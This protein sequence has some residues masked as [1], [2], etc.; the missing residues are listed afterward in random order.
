MIR[1]LR[2]NLGTLSLS[3]VLSFSVWVL[4]V[5]SQDPLEERTL[6]GSV[7][8]EYSG[9]GTNLTVL[10]NPPASARVTLRA[11]DSVWGEITVEDIHLLA[12][13]TGLEEG[14]YEIPI[15]VMLSRRPAKVVLV[16]PERVRV[17]LEPSATV[18]LPVAVQPEGEPAVGHRVASVVAAPST[19]IVSGPG[20]LIARV[21]TLR[22]VVSLDSRRENLQEAVAIQPVDQ[23]GVLVSGVT[24]APRQVRVIVTLEQ[25]GGYRSVAVIPITQGQ[26]LAGYRV[27]NITVTPTLVTVVSTD[28]AAIDLL[29][30]FVETAA[31]ILSGASADIQQRVALSLPA[32][33]SVVGAPTVL[34]QV[35]IAPIESSITITRRLQLQGLGPGLSA[36]VSPASVSL[37]LTGPLLTLER[38]L[39]EQVQ[40]VIDLT[41][42]EP[43]THQVVPIVVDL[44][45]NVVVETVLPDLIEVTVQLGGPPSPTSPSP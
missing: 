31:I 7:P 15:Q 3:L 27:T 24:V 2:E 40:V 42:L 32:G 21:R 13:L 18:T 19:A 1:W 26:V 9:L 10:D 16:D 43:G 17:T 22:A 4:A 20:S 36:Q 33:F 28:P 39:P 29:P 41:G 45:E 44:P 11:P 34:V 14:T 8:I 12:D 37:I 5:N 23:D 25:L 30:G 38:L 6:P 35:S